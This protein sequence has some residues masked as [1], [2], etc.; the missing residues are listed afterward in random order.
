[1]AEDRVEALRQVPL[2]RELS[3]KDLRMVLEISKEV[4]HPRGKAVVEEDRSAAGF[5]LILEGT[6]EVSTGGSAV[7]T[8]GP[9]DYF[10]EMSLLDGKPRSATV[11]ATSDLRTLSVPVWNFRKLLDDHPSIMRA[12]LVE[13]SERVRRLSAAPHA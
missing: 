3:D 2:F 9:T 10:G 6:A 12:M 4:H 13:L 5:H 1:M 7:S 11:T 8:M